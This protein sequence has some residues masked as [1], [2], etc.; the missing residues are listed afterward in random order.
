V[1]EAP[2]GTY[3]LQLHA[4]FGFAAAGA[5]VPYLA[6]LGV[7]HLYLSP[8]LQAAPGSMH[9]YDVV[10]H[11]AVSADLGGESDLVALADEAHRH[12]LG[13]VADVVPNHMAIPT[14]QHLNPVLWD[15]LRHGQ[16]SESA[17]WFDVDWAACGGRL[18][19]PI[20]GQGLD[21]TIDAEELV[22]AAR[23]GEPVV[24]YHETVLPLAPGTADGD[25]AT[26]LA[27]QHYLLGSWREKDRLL[28]Y[29]RFFDVDT[30]IAIRVEL[31]DVFDA[32]HALLLDLSRRGVFDG[33]RIDHPDG[34]ADPEAYLQRLH[35]ATDGAYVV[36]EKILEPG[37]RL[38]PG[39]RC[40]GT[41][42]YDAIRAVQGALL[43]PV[44]AELTPLWEDAAGS[45]TVDQTVE[46]AKRDVVEHLLQPE[47]HRLTREAV[48]AI[49]DSPPELAAA[50]SE[51]LIGFEVYRAYVRPGHPVDP[52]S[53][54]HLD[55]AVARAASSRPDLQPV[56]ERLRAP[57]RGAAPELAVRFQQTCGPVMAKGVEDTAFYRYHRLVA[58]NEV[59]GDLNALADPGPHVLHAWA[60]AQ[61][62][63]FPHGMTALSTHDTK[64]SE[65]V[66]ARLIAL[67]E[68]PAAWESAWAPIRAAADA[69]G[70][71]RPAAYLVFQTVLGAWPLSAQRLHDYLRKALREAKQHTA[72]VDRDEAY[73]QRVL[74]LAT[75]VTTP[76]PALMRLEH[77]LDSAGPAIRATTLAAKLLQLTVPGAPDV[78][79]GCELVALSLVDPDNRRPVDYDDRAER[80]G[81]LDR[82]EGVRDLDDEKLRVT[83]AALRL[84]RQRPQT[85]GARAGYRP[86]DTTS[87]HLLAYLRG[88]DVLVAVTRHPHRL[89]A[90]GGW[91]DETLR[92]PD[93]HWADVLVNHTHRAG[94]R[95]C[96]LFGSLP[97]ALLVKEQA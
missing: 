95:A 35:A 83:S 47:V 74:D 42:G 78:Y 9:G 15:V 20:L 84:R 29:R 26:V 16:Q 25:V 85:F 40:S 60:A 94:V 80:L 38:A 61:A 70:V 44:E 81:R 72:W 57:L 91:R 31:P 8:V 82:G 90:T 34:L 27:R 66:R 71:D 49:D 18:G 13:L 64:R 79:Q 17:S 41:T 14:P 7:S 28:N 45:F 6:R 75:S 36:V 50:V 19:L 12:G 67:A 11:G 88:E 46:Q 23:D 21:E 77:V 93:G 32:T 30:L 5:I 3:R 2:T 62:R 53:E 58:L 86:C 48:T 52:E 37:E 55:S 51:L 56:L 43:P 69:A 92:L 73:E 65:D 22:I 33:F 68:D 89:G 87:E 76:G 4:G 54:R 96:D 97:V 1:A 10:D 63:H 59:G 39:W 24:R